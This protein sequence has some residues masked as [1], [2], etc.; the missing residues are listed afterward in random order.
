M[1]CQDPAGSRHLRQAL[2]APS[3]VADFPKDRDEYGHIERAGLEWQ[4]NPRVGNREPRASIAV[5][6]QTSA[7]LR[8]HF[9]LDVDELKV[10]FRDRVCEGQA[11]VS[12]PGS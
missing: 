5:S 8:K 11:E 2:K 10:A 9:W 7:G 1:N 12:R 6:G 4:V 3:C